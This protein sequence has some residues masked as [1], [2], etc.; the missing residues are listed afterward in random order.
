MVEQRCSSYVKMQ[1]QYWRE[2]LR[3]LAVAND[4]RNEM[5]LLNIL[6][7]PRVLFQPVGTLRGLR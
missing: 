2:Q 7:E 5:I 4:G 6:R 1:G 3:V